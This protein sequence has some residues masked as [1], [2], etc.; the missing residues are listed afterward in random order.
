MKHIILLITLSITISCSTKKTKVAYDPFKGLKGCFLLYNLKTSTYEKTIGETCQQRF[1][2]CSTFKVPLAVMAFDSK[3]LK[4]EKRLLLALDKAQISE[5]QSK[6]ISLGNDI[7][8]LK[9]EKS[10]SVFSI[11]SGSSTI[12]YFPPKSQI[13]SYR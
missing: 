7:T 12:I 5:N 2:A 6:I 10:K 9:N 4:D 13:S 8:Q 11:L 3:I 1:P